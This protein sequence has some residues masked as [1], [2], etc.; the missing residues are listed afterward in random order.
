MERII[1]TVGP[2]FLHDKIKSHHD[3]RYL[4]RINGAHGNSDNII[5]TINII[6][7]QNSDAQILLDLPGNKIRTANF[8][9]PL[10]VYDGKSFFIDFDQ[11]NFTSF[12]KYIKEGDKVAAS[13]STLHFVVENI[14]ERSIKFRSLTNG[15]LQNNKGFHIQGVS[16]QLPLFFKKDLDLIKI[17]NEFNIDYVGLSFT[18]TA[19]DVAEAKAKISPP[20]IVKIETKLAVENIDSILEMNDDFLIDR[21]DLSTDVGLI[22]LSYY[23]N[24][25]IKK[26][27]EKKKKVTLA[28]QF[29]KNMEENQIPSIAEIIDLVNTLK[30]GIN[31]IQL[32]EETAIGKYP[33]HCLD[34]VKEAFLHVEKSKD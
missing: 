31:G 14:G 2:S 6:R 19:E 34:I 24:F 27:K 22:N 12:H 28:T 13:D 18:R 33:I 29:L 7:N 32:S 9:E 23:Q 16:S 8:T 5:E 15:I 11:F 4:Y 1:V 17:A 30:L 21:G 25:I 3:S 10:K 26:V 20:L